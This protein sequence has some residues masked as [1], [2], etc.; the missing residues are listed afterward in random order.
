MP[1]NHIK[2]ELVKESDGYQ[3]GED[4]QANDGSEL[5]QRRRCG[6]L[7]RLLAGICL[8]LTCLPRM[9]FNRL[10]KRLGESIECLI[11]TLLLVFGSIGYLIYYLY[12][13]TVPTWMQG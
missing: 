10:T 13:S 6:C 5:H 3:D 9:I 1:S 8:I 4:P 2:Y 7:S 12:V 11:L